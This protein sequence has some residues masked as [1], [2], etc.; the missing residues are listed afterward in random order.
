MGG[1]H[2]QVYQAIAHLFLG[3]LIGAA[4]FQW[5]SAKHGTWN[6]PSNDPDENQAILKAVIVVALSGVEVACF[7][8]FKFFA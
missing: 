5:K 8:W 4:W 3:W 6:A 7:V 2:D 1:V